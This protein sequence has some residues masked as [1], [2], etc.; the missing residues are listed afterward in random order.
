M[1]RPADTLL[2]TR[3]N[4]VRNLI[5]DMKRYAGKG[6]LGKEDPHCGEQ[7]YWGYMKYCYGHSDRDLNDLLRR[8]RHR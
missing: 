2:S 7:N 1:K 8:V 3:N 6:P 4:R 5:K